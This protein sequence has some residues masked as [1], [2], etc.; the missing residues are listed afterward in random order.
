MLKVP[1]SLFPLLP[2]LF[3]VINEG[4]AY[5]SRYR[6]TYGAPIP[7]K[8]SVDSAV[9]LTATGKSFVH[10]SSPIFSRP[11]MISQM[12]SDQLSGYVHQFT[13]YGGARPCGSR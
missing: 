7:P 13:L 2:F 1:L 10:A 3:Q 12:L 8:V 5:A 9:P 11:I 4:R 6:E